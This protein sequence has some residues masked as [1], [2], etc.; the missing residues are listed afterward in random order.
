VDRRFKA[1]PPQGA[2]R[3][4]L[5]DR[6]GQGRA[7]PAAAIKKPSAGLLGETPS[8]EQEQAEVGEG[9]PEL[10]AA[11]SAGQGASFQILIDGAQST[12]GRADVAG[13]VGFLGCLARC[14][15]ML[16]E[17]PLLNGPDQLTPSLLIERGRQD[18]RLLRSF[19]GSQCICR[20][21]RHE[22]CL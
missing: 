12:N 15:S 9:E 14:L 16:R 2:T 19:C 8:Y 13:W 21:G 22:N 18:L 10:V 1:Q 3:S 5:V 11:K 4:A 20:V 6:W 17:R 7:S